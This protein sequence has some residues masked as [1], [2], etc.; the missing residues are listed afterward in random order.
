MY[1]RWPQPRLYPPL[2]LAPFSAAAVWACALRPELFG[3]PP[4]RRAV[5]SSP[6]EPELSSGRIGSGSGTGTG[7][8][9]PG[10]RG[11]LRFLPLPLLEFRLSFGIGPPPA[12]FGLELL[13]APV[14]LLVEAKRRT[15]PPRSGGCPERRCPSDPLHKVESNQSKPIEHTHTINFV[16]A[17]QAT[18]Q[19]SDVFW[20]AVTF[21]WCMIS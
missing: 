16:C 13:F 21:G 10:A 15:R 7:C 18:A 19:T 14:L 5:S 8:P 9:P 11:L 4:P 12:L 2:V 17:Q 20:Q 3:F 1:W 6:P